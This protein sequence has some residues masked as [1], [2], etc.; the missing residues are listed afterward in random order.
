MHLVKQLQPRARYELKANGKT[1]TSLQ[2]NQSGQVKFK[3]SHGDATPQS[4]ELC[5]AAKSH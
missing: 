5:L 3:V 2:A 1:I 4:L